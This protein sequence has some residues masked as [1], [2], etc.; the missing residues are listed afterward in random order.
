[1]P[2]QKMQITM[3]QPTEEKECPF[4]SKKGPNCPL[5]GASPTSVNLDES[6]RFGFCDECGG[7]FPLK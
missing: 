5:C 1:M 3:N 2:E 6:G 7:K 4:V